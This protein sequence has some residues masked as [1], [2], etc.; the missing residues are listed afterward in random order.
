LNDQHSD[1]S[2]P[3]FEL[4]MREVDPDSVDLPKPRG[5]LV[6]V[7]L[8]GLIII[9]VAIICVNFYNNYRNRSVIFESKDKRIS[10]KA[11]SKWNTV[12]TKSQKQEKGT[13]SVPDLVLAKSGTAIYAEQ[14][15][16][17]SVVS[18]V[19]GATIEEV[20]NMWKENYKF[21]Q[22]WGGDLKSDDKG[23]QISSTPL[24]VNIQGY[25]A[26]QT[27]FDELTRLEVKVSHIVTILSSSNKYY[28][29]EGVCFRSNKEDFLKEYN[30][31]IKTINFN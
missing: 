26:L 10:I 31:I 6:S 28:I 22:I 15:G 14:I 3:D 24:K 16:V 27:D 5:N 18:D 1:F 23:K 12:A 29:I 8:S 9:T 30:K 7:I 4:N 19:S 2:K 11:S 17:S 21:S 25:E 20:Y 13:F